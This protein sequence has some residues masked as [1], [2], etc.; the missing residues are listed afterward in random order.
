MLLLLVKQIYIKFRLS[1]LTTIWFHFM[2]FKIHHIFIFLSKRSIPL[3]RFYS[4]LHLQKQKCC[5]SFGCWREY[6]T[7]IAVWKRETYCKSLQKTFFETIFINQTFMH[8]DII[9]L[10]WYLKEV[11]NEE[12]IIKQNLYAGFWNRIPVY[13]FPELYWKTPRLSILNCPLFS[14]LFPTTNF[15]FWVVFRICPR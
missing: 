8:L 5:Y 3:S 7:M 14:A 4:T 13:R 9:M 10:L 2:F 15:H 1:L 11:L 6:P 12:K